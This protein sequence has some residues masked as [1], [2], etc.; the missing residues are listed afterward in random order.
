M[1]EVIG[2][3]TSV[4]Q[5]VQ[6]SGA[7]L[8]GG[9]NFLSKVA[10]AP[11]EIRSLLTETA[12]I[13]SL[14]AQLQQIADTSPQA[15]SDDALQAL[16]RVGVFQ[17]CQ[18]TLKSIE[19]ALAKCEQVNGQDAK[20]FG[21]KLMWPFKEKETKDALQRLHHMRGLLANAIEAN[22]ASA[23]RRIEIG[24]GL[25]SDEMENISEQL[26]AQM[27]REEA[28][29]VVTWV[30]PAPANGAHVSL[31]SALSRH[32]P[33]TGEWL[34]H[35][36]QFQDWED[37]NAGTMW[38]TGLPGAGKTLL[39]ASIIRHVQQLCTDTTAI[40]YFFCDHRDRAKMAHEN[41]AASVVRQVMEASPL[42]LERGRVLYNEKSKKGSRPCHK[43]EYIPLIRSSIACL[44]EVFVIVDALDESTEGDAIAQSLTTIHNSGKSAGC[45]IR[46]LLTSRFDARTQGRYPNLA[47]THIILAENMRPDTQH[48]IKEELQLRLAKGVLKVRNTS[49]MPVIQRH[50]SLCAGTILQA[51][52]QI[53]YICAAKSDRE[54]K[55]MVQRL[56]NGLGYTYQILLHNIATRYPTK[57]Q[58][59]QKLFRCL[60]AAASPMTARQ[61]AEV[62]AMQPEECDLDHD[63]V[64]TDP[65]DVLEPVSA[66]VRIEDLGGLTSVVKLCHYSFQEYL[67]SSEIRQSPASAFHVD[68]SEAHAWVAGLCLRY[69]TFDAFSKPLDES[70]DLDVDE[71]YA[72]RR[73]AAVNWYRHVTLAGDYWSARNIPIPFLYL[74]FDSGEGPPCY[75]R[76]QDL[77]STIYCDTDFFDYSPI[78]LCIWLGLNATATNL[79]RQL[80]SLDYS[81][82]NGLTCLNA[83][84]KE[85]N[86]YIA[87]YLLQ[88]GANA[89]QPTSEPEFPRALTPIH[90]A[91]EF[92]ASQVFEMLL[93]HGANPY[94][95]STSR[96]TPFYRACR[97]GDLDMV[98]KLKEHGC[99]I[100]VQTWDNWTP[101]I[102][103]IVNNHEDVLDLLI[104][105]GADLITVTD[106]DMT[107]L[108]CAELFSQT[109]M[110]EKIERA[111]AE[112]K[113]TLPVE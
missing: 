100:N 71:R 78:C 109:S 36:K 38:I 14:L 4:A 16:E 31:A 40:V 113:Q 106:D 21:R 98:R 112:L 17:E 18:S 41:F 57:I 28:Q 110:A 19:R 96:A 9:Y 79:I 29:R 44:K 80:P 87:K 13:N 56:P 86:L 5:L 93:E 20:N 84:A 50:I 76:W 104:E 68:R 77:L 72:F 51:R 103:A 101:I 105:W 37:S 6:L 22:S 69:L 59:V 90:F 89:D 75:T 24:Q 58:E 62:L 91:A 53:D 12:A 39:C 111:V 10:R 85:N 95:P 94:L 34:L 27:S 55:H 102:E 54:I 32:I 43:E 42:S 107:P 92:C 47:M 25:I 74:F 33:G 11:S 52:L 88:H 49:I 61:L 63:A 66:L 70:L 1:A 35:S 3:V 99:D 97:G 65:Y 73:Y 82:E 46:T 45:R 48:Y 2:T 7:L 64:A 15:A 83:A 30:C 67:S 23:I 8:A 108:S 60:I 81:F 26:S